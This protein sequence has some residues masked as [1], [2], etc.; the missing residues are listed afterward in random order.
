V[1][2]NPPRSGPTPAFAAL[3][4]AGVAFTPHSYVHDPRAESFGLEAATALGVEPGRV[5]KTLMAVVDD[6]LCVGVV[7]VMGSLDLKL[8]ADALGGKRAQMADAAQ[9]QRA[10]GY[11]LGGIS[12]M[13]QKKTHRTVVDRSS[14]QWATVFVSGGRRGLEAELAPAD[15]VRVT[16]AVVAR[17]AR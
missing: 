8:L 12:P 17:I 11:V 13:G 5:F 15:L 2:A 4:R 1:A 10:T 14:A 6:E 16:R 9:A 3:Q 7:P